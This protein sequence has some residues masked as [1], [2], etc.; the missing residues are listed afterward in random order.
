MVPGAHLSLVTDDKG[1]PPPGDAAVTNGDATLAARF[2][3]RLAGLVGSA[4][5]R[6]WL[7]DATLE[8]VAGE[9][10]LLVGTRFTADWIRGHFDQ[11]VRQAADAVGLKAAPVIRMRLP[12]APSP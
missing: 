7:N 5:A 8:L 4:A 6:S 2:L 3:A 12:P 11:P 1:T 9:W 10:V